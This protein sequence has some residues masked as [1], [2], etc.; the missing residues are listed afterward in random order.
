MDNSMSGT[1]LASIFRS[2]K[3]EATEEKR[4]IETQH[5]TT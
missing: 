4:V 5:A 3:F 1:N 2:Q